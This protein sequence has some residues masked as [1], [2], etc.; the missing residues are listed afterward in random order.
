MA[1]LSA[2]RVQPPPTPHAPQP[3]PIYTVTA[4]IDGEI[5]PAFANYASLQKPRDRRLNTVTV[6]I[7]NPGVAPLRRRITVQI[8]GWSDEEIQTVIVPSGEMQTLQFAPTFLSRL[9]RNRE[10]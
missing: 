7:T 1:R 5:F 6:T 9:F 3:D 10:I 4:G 2:L 8:P